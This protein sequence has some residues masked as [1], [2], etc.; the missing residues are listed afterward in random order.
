MTAQI[1]TCFRLGAALMLAALLLCA[2]QAHAQNV[3]N[4]PTLAAALSTTTS[5]VQLSSA[6]GV[7][8]PGPN[9][10][11]LVVLVVDNEA[12][13]V[14]TIS[15]TTATVARGQYGTRRVAHLSGA[16]VWVAPD[17]ALVRGARPS[18]SCT[19]TN[20]PY[21][22]LVYISPGES[23]GRSGDTFDCLGG[24]FVQTNQPVAFFGSTVTNATSITPTGTSF[25]ISGT[26]AIATIVVPAGWAAGNCL[27][28]EPLAAYTTGTGGNILIAST[29]VIGKVMIM[30]WDGAKWLPSY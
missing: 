8:A 21:V 22:P 20:L 7:T 13:L 14:Q 15:G 16:T 5:T 27:Y 25:K 1:K 9:Q 18:G 6:T 30:C 10:T 11:N 19:R 23:T 24:Q 4:A 29:A 28:I 3:L 26:G 17:K 2:P 12:M